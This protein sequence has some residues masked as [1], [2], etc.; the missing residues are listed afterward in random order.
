MILF[1]DVDGP[2]LDHLIRGG[3]FDLPSPYVPIAIILPPC[4]ILIFVSALDNRVM[5]I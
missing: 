2:P 5:T 1:F 4:R 3:F